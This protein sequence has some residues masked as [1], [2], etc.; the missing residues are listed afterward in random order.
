MK[1]KRELRGEL[2][3]A[4]AASFLGVS[5]ASVR[6]WGDG[7]LFPM[8]RVG[9]RR[10]RRFRRADLAAFLEGGTRQGTRAATLV[11]AIGRARVAPGTHLATLFESEA[12]RIR[13]AVPFLREGVALGQPC[14]LVASGEILDGYLAAIKAGLEDELAE[15]V[16]RGLFV[17]APGPGPTVDA[18]LAFWEDR[19]VAAAN[20]GPTIVR[21]VGDMACVAASLPVQPMLTF[22]QLLSVLIRRLPAVLLCQYDVRAFDG[23]TVLAALKA[24]PDTFEVGLEKL[25]G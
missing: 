6:R 13:Y 7:G 16:A 11:A 18:A 3:T 22:E 14:F 2:N 4:E 23:P 15:A 21:G 10:Q 25:I 12:G 5:E 17:T 20:T 9:Q 1:D 24:H 19:I 8:E